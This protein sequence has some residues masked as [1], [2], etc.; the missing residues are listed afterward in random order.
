MLVHTCL[1]SDVRN[2]KISEIDTGELVG[3]LI[4]V[5]LSDAFFKGR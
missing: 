3:E 1:I 2:L 5:N 4:E